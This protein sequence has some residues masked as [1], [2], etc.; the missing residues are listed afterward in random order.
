[1]STAY[2]PPFAPGLWSRIHE[3]SPS[4]LR[5][6]ACVRVAR[7]GAVHARGDC[8]IRLPARGRGHDGRLD[9]G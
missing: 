8:R 2:R 9:D 5:S 6:V 7:D 1:M 4:P 3:A